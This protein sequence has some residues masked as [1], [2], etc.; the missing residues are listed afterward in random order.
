MPPEKIHRLLKRQ[1]KRFFGE[2][3]EVPK[4]WRGFIDMVNSAYH[5]NDSDRNMLERSLELSSQ[6]LLQANSEMRA[7]FEA[8]P[9]IIF[10]IDVDGKILDCKTGNSSDLLFSRPDIIGSI[11]YNV[12]SPRVAFKFRKVMEDVRTSKAAVSFEYSLLL[13]ETENFYEARWIPFLE[14]QAVIII[15]NITDLKEAEGALK[16]S[17]EIYTKLVDTLPDIVV[18]TNLEGMI[19][20]VN[21][22]TEKISGYKR[23]DIEGKNILEFV[24]P[25]DQVRAMK[26]ITLLM[27]MKLDPKEYQFIMKNGRQ[28]S[29][30]VNSEVLRKE[31]NTPFGIVHICRDITER[32]Q[33]EQALRENEKR[34]HL[35]TDNV[36]DTVWLMDMNMRT[37]WIS[38]SV[39]R[40]RGFT[41]E[42]LQSI[43]PEKHVTPQSSR[44][45]MELIEK[46]LTPERMANPREDISGKAELEFYCKD[47][48]TIWA[49]TV[50]TVLRDSQGIPAGF[51]G[52]SR[53]TTE[54]RKMEEVLR[55]SEKKYRLLTETITDIV[56]TADMN[57]RELYVSPSIQ[58]VLGY[59]QEERLRQPFDQQLTPA[60][61][62]LAME[63]LA[64]E[65]ALEARGD[66]DPDRKVNLVL[67][68]YHK[69]GST[70]WI[71]TNI[72][73]LRNDQGAI[74]ELHGVSR[75]ITERKQA[76]EELHES[77]RRLESIIEFLP[78]A[79]LV[80]DQEGVVIAWNRAMEAMTGFK[81]KDVFGK[82]NYEYAL[83]FYGERRPILIDYALH[84]D[85]EMEKRY[86]EIQ[87]VDNILFG[88]ALTPNIP[89]GNVHLSGTASVLQ[90]SK[91]NVIAAIECIRDVTHIKETEVKLNLE[92][93]KFQALYDLAV[94]L[95]AEKTLE[96]N[97]IFIV[98]KSRE[99]LGTDTAFIALKDTDEQHLH[100]HTLS[101]IQT[102]DFKKVRVPSHQGF[103]GLIM[104]NRQGYIID[105][106]FNHK[107]IMPISR[108]IIRK[109]GL[110]SAMAVPVHAGENNLGVL[111]VANRRATRFTQD[112]LDTL[113]LFGNLAA[114]EILRKQV[115]SDLR[116]SETKYRTVFENSG[117]AMVI[118]ENDTRISL[119]N[120]EFSRMVGYSKD[121]IEG[122]KS[123]TEFVV[124]ED[125]SKMRDQHTKRRQPAKD[126]DNYYEFRLHDRQENL[127][128]IYLKIDMI[129]GT[130]KS[131]AS[132]IDITENKRAEAALQA[133]HDELE[134][135]VAERTYE[136]TAANTNLKELFQKQD[137]NIDLAKNI[138]AMINYR[139]CRHNLIQNNVDLFFTAYYLP[140]YAEGGDHYFVKNL[141]ERY[142]DIHKTA[143]SLKDQSGH[144][145]SCILRSI[146]TDLIHNA[147]LINTPGFSIEETISQLNREICELPFF[148]ED[149]FFTA[150]NAEID[151]ENMTMRYVS[152]GHPPFVLI[153]NQDIVCLPSLDSQG[154][155]LPIGVH[156][157][158]DFMSEEIQLQ[159]GD[160]LIFFTDG[161]TDIPHKEGRHVLNAE[162]MKDMIA[163]IVQDEPHLPVSILMA[164]LFNRINGQAGDNV[165][166]S[167]GFD[168]D[169]TL[170]GLELENE[171]YE[172]EDIVRPANLDD[173]DH[174]VNHLYQK[175]SAEWEKKG[176]PSSE[177]R[178]RMVLEEAMVNAWSH[179]NQEDPQ[180][181]I[182]VRRRYGNDAVLEVI[183][184]GEGFNFKTFY[185]PTC[186]EN[187]L[188]PRGRGNFIMRFLTEETQW[189]DGGRHL[190][191]YFS[192][193]DK[194]G[195]TSRSFPGLNLWQRYKKD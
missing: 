134:K 183:D 32:R 78:D 20:F 180:K 34:F 30:E 12:P 77:Q 9:D 150:I 162:D 128:Y 50:I 40:Q 184:E 28:V 112:A 132:L 126:A 18:R 39:V 41:L 179:G 163:E 70:R 73:T 142:P 19:L 65:L 94:N 109:E 29:F 92:L 155:N 172:Y 72:N 143:I 131:V 188:N 110:I 175:I 123:W 1:L 113:L 74:V 100:M 145:V 13:H 35:I 167:H 148:G 8:V 106:Y 102:A 48:S 144:E 170:L 26:N 157:T 11:I 69:D 139:P 101:G 98:E 108:D 4:E 158:V 190:I 176:F 17:E 64:R 191:S 58:R 51:L 66:A 43:P 61:Y 97:L 31:D 83:P 135:R 82:G 33:T 91:G 52:L 63:T 68:Y 178:L 177:S 125:L 105:D 15:R 67:E 85:S 129:P 10:R 25:E 95:S 130:L 187:L 62:A 81:K 115:E 90:D 156:Q 46:T 181:M 24:A 186:K 88:Q 44:T 54:R 47:G 159:K 146:I 136:L 96:D 16:K 60:S 166:I 23:D 21:D 79:T 121:E 164:R 104:T 193:E 5:E 27:K 194:S 168:D 138:L 53:D 182:V 149:N 84:W 154:R 127:K 99:L 169:V 111:Y 124:P 80:I 114:I 160:K 117:S 171:S 22:H 37:T 93:S 42:E 75:D 122:R 140:C 118:I 107:D 192:K 7:I 103:G 3:F 195:H 153:R 71:E 120:E 2:S 173:F 165:V 38:E 119:A 133:A 36:Q 174:C 161:L 87:R 137:V 14:D 6:E 141:S 185:D 151:H 76:E 189:K 49:D 86:T 59:T 152:A 89:P 56:W 45:V 57:L 116:K 147:L 55:E